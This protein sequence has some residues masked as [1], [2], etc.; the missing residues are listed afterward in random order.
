MVF[1]KMAEGYIFKPA[2]LIQH[3]HVIN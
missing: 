3:D 2:S 1:K